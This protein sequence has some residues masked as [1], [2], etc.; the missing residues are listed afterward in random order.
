MSNDVK[1]DNSDNK[2]AANPDQAPHGDAPEDADPLSKASQQIAELEATLAAEK[3]RFMRQIAEFDNSRRRAEKDMEAFK[4]YANLPMA[5]ELVNVADNLRRALDAMPLDGV[6]EPRT[7]QLLEGV[8]ATER[9]L[10]TIFEKYH[11]QK[12]SPLGQPFDPKYHHAMMEQTDTG[13]PPNTV[14]AVLFPGYMIFDRLLR[15]AGVAVAKGEV[16]RVDTKA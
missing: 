8:L 2:S 3:D 15:E 12:F 4:K 16:K 13:Q 10:L 11:I 5:A 14:V 6:Q 9:E 1:D 7:R